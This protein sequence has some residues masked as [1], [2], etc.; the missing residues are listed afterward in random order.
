MTIDEKVQQL[1]QLMTQNELDGY[2]IP[3]TDPHLGEYIPAHWAERSWISGFTGSAGTVVITHTFAGLWTDSRYFVQAEEQLAESVIELVRLTVP[4]TP[5]HLDWLINHLPDG[6]RIGVNGT[7]VPAVSVEAMS[8]RFSNKRF[9]LETQLDLIGSIWTDR[10]ALPVDPIIEHTAEFAGKSRSEKIDEVRS[11]MKALGTD[12]H[13]LGSLDEIA[14]LFNLRGQD[15]PFNPLFVSYALLSTDTVTLFIDQNKIP[16]DLSAKLRLDGIELQSYSDVIQ[17]IQEIPAGHKLLVDSGR[18]NHAIMQVVPAGVEV[19]ESLGP[20]TRLKAIKNDTEI[21]GL[22]RVMIKDG[23][24]WVKFLH[25]LDSRVGHEPITELSAANKLEAFRA[26]QSDYMGA[27]FHPISSFGV[28]GSMVHYAVDEESDIPL[29]PAGIYL[30]DTGGHYLDGTTDTTRTVTLGR[31]TP[32]QKKDFTLALKGTLAVSML[33]FPAGTKGYQMDILARKALW[34]HALNY[35]HGT[36]HGVGFF[37]NVHEGPQTIGTGA[38][39][40]MQT[41]IVPGMITTVEPAIYREGSHGMRTENM[42][43][44]VTDIAN[45]FGQFYRF[46]TLTLVPIDTGLINLSLLSNEERRWLNEYHQRVY[47]ALADQLTDEEQNWLKD[48]TQVI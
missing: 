15:V 31:V 10:P 11:E 45:E 8:K 19:V 24:A 41:A 7:M 29:E 39:G 33:R 5:E 32:E 28:H 17:G 46:E 12:F 16:D 6:A 37:L 42:T 2:I 13:F 34:D 27:S 1:R 4:H 23:L 25:W 40:H 21:E 47:A 26:E 18:T 44:C 43:L 30:C 36:G 48:R 22:K 3:S 35:G 9:N 14:W 38:T 20:V